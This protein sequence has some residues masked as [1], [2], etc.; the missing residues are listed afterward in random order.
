MLEGK[1]EV[2]VSMFADGC[3]RSKRGKDEE[4]AAPGHQML[5]PCL[6]EHG[7]YVERG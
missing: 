6:R 7:T 3:C 4:R 5:S 1:A 2:I